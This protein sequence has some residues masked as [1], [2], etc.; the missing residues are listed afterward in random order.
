M[1]VSYDFDGVGKR[2]VLWTR[3]F[4]VKQNENNDCYSTIVVPRTKTMT[5][6]VL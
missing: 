2:M 5:V 3:G 4:S 1:T 6:T